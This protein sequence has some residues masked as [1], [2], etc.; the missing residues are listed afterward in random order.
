MSD[1][2]LVYVDQELSLQMAA[3]VMGSEVQVATS[4]S[5]TA[6]INFKV[7]FS[8]RSGVETSVTTKVAD[9]LPEAL[10]RGVRAKVNTKIDSLEL[11]RSRMLTGTADSFQPGAAV[12]IRD[13]I[14]RGSVDQPGE[15]ALAGGEVCAAARIE[16]APYFCKAFLKAEHGSLVDEI[17][18]Q[19]IDVLGVLRWTRAYEVPGGVAQNLGLRVAAVWLR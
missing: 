16:S 18:D 15:S 9:L 10:A 17:A 8:S 19:P 7:V 3:G 4:Q 14:L 12:E 11:V 2:V 5:D 1:G 13:V 6:G